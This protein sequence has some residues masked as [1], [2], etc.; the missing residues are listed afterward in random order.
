VHRSQLG[1]YRQEGE[2]RV[3]DFCAHYDLEFE[4]LQATM[5]ERR[6]AFEKRAFY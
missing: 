1:K 4:Q 5:I 3:D 6:E 2:G